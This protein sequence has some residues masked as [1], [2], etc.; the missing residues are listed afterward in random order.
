M[1]FRRRRAA[2]QAL[3]ESVLTQARS[4]EF[5]GAGRAPDTVDG[6]FEL[7]ALHLA[8]VIRRLQADGRKGA[9]IAQDLFDAFVRDMDANLRELGASDARFGKKM[10]HIVQSFYGRAKSYT[11]ALEAEGEGDLRDALFRNLF[12]G[13]APPEELNR[14]VEYCRRSAE[15][16]AATGP[17]DWF[18]G[19]RIFPPPPAES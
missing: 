10:R 14:M 17:D 6:R 7:L 18:G 5:Y 2:V 16:L 15:T 12:D 4:P 13:A 9:A 1:F 3:Y 11:D 19:A 8:L